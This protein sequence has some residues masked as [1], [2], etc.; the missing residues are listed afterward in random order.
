[1]KLRQR[2]VD[3]KLAL[4]SPHLHTA[5]APAPTVALE[6]LQIVSLAASFRQGIRMVARASLFVCHLQTALSLKSPVRII[7]M[8]HSLHCLPS[9]M[10]WEQ[11]ITQLYVQV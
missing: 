3:I 10:L 7:Q 9:P 6:W 1:M 4:S 2:Y 11:A 5:M 8:K